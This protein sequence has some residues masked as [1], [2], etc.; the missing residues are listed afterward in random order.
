[1]TTGTRRW[2]LGVFTAWASLTL[3]PGAN[4]REI[5]PETDLCPAINALPPGDELVLLPGDYFGPCAIRQ[6]GLPGAPSVIRAK[7]PSHRPRVI[8]AGRSAN[9]VEV[10]T[11]HL[12]IR[13]LEFG[14][15]ERDVDAI[16][17]FGARDIVVEDCDFMGLGGIAVVANHSDVRGLTVRRNQIRNSEATAMY[18]GCH[19]GIGCA[20]SGLTIEGNYIRRVR[21]PEPEI[22]YG[23]QIKLN[24]I[25]IIRDNVVVD[26]KGPGIMVYGSRDMLGASVIERNIVAESLKSAGIVVGGGPAIVRNNVTIGSIGQ[27]ILLQ[28]YAQRG[29]L[30]GVVIAHNTAYGNQSGGIVGENGLRG[31]VI[32]NNAVQARPGTPAL[33]TPQAGLQLGG[34]VT[35]GPIF[36]FT[37]AEA[38]DF[39]PLPGGLLVGAG[40]RVLGLEFWA[41]IED[42][43]GAARGL[44]ANVGAIERPAGPISLDPVR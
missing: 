7:D 14:P 38:R 26:T 41:P 44:P 10:R 3:A 5:G 43:F 28:D 20:V 33:P 36:C 2:I 30:R 35:C 15:T 11:S 12:V 1:M 32:V 39:S 8:Y 29:L 25:G 34:N 17:I 22:G 16:R 31:A 6:G 4:S 18:F 40:V 23:I 13:G 19:D 9:V 42:L 21:A 37:N 27:G 24:S